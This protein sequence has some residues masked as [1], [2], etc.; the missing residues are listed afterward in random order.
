MDPPKISAMKKFPVV[1][2]FKEVPIESVELL[3]MFA[4]ASSAMIGGDIFWIEG[5]PPGNDDLRS[6]FALPAVLNSDSSLNRKLTSSGP[7][8]DTAPG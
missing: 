3:I 2:K 7:R 6:G 1:R 4:W 8:A 5:S